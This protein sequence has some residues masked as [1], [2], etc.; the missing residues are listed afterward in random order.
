MLTVEAA[1]PV[2]S[3]VA[4]LAVAESLTFSVSTPVPTRTAPMSAFSLREPS[5]TVRLSDEP[6]ESARETLTVDVN[7]LTALLEPRPIAV[8][9]AR[10]VRVTSTELLLAAAPAA[11]AKRAEAPVIP[12]A[13]I[14]LAVVEVVEQSLQHRRLTTCQR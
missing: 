8:P 6:E 11:L 1:K 12:D 3:S 2:K 7:P 4:S 9:A 14:A 5:S 13:S 10:L